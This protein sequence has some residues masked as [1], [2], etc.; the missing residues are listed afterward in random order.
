MKNLNTWLY[1]GGGLLLAAVLYFTRDKWMPVLGLGKK[2]EEKKEP[3]TVSKPEKPKETLVEEKPKDK[4]KPDR[5]QEEKPTLKRIAYTIVD[6]TPLYDSKGGIK[7]YLA[8]GTL[9]GT[10][11]GER[12]GYFILQG[13]TTVNKYSVSVKSIP[14][15]L[16]R[17]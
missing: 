10:I 17:T 4:P 1:L 13:D 16:A 5:P 3:E 14:V 11:I 15:R 8:K 6:K 7:T 2:E 12:D 9:A